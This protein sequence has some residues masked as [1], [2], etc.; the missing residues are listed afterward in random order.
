MTSIKPISIPTGFNMRSRDFIRFQTTST[1]NSLAFKSAWQKILPKRKPKPRFECQYCCEHKREDSF[2]ANGVMPYSC[3]PHFTNANRVCKL[4]I[5]A[6]FKAQLDSKPLLNCG[7]P[8]C[9]I[10]WDPEEWKWMVSIKTQK[11]IKRLDQLAR[12]QVLVP[13]ELPDGATVD[14]LLEKG[15][16]FW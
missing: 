9:G 3:R 11:L 7:C 4:C 1:L 16:R 14:T 10:A 6:A 13:N 5:D 2:V 12:Q 15:T 8:Q